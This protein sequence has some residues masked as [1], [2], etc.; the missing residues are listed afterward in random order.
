MLSGMM[1]NMNSSTEFEADIISRDTTSP[2]E[3]W[4][5]FIK[6]DTNTPKYA[7]PYLLVTSLKHSIDSRLKENVFPGCRKKRNKKRKETDATLSTK[8]KIWKPK[9]KG[10]YHI[11]PKKKEKPPEEKGKPAKDVA[12]PRVMKWDGKL[13][14]TFQELHKQ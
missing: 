9:K 10:T 13:G 4:F 11:T 6:Y 8:E 12:L 3:N 14:G 2:A 7:R 1:Q 5:K